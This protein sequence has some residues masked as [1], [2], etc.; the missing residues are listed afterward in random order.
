MNQERYDVPTRASS[1]W[2]KV[3]SPEVLVVRPIEFFFDFSSPYSYLAA[4]QL[5]AIAARTGAS[6]EWKPFV[7]H[8]VFKAT[9]N[10]MPARVPAKAQYMLKDLERW[11]RHYNVGFRFNSRFPVNAIKAMRLVIAAEDQGRAAETALAMFKAV[12][13]E[14]RDVTDPKELAAIAEQAGLDVE[15]AMAAIES[16]EVKDRLRVYTDDATRRGAFGAPA[17][18]VGDEL[19]WG[20]DRL[21]FVEEAV[22]GS[23]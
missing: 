19:F 8:A 6:I 4:T 5:P 9:E 10:Q 14:D 3:R 16:Q 20:N 15:R 11:A 22:K 18:F 13:A 1:L 12:W 23:S 17:I 2:G 21:H 7:L